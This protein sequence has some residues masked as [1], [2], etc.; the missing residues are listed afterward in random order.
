MYLDKVVVPQYAITLLIKNPEQT[1]NCE[2]FYHDIGDYLSREDKLKI[3][4]EFGDIAGIEAVKGWQSISPNDSYDW[5]NQR[6]PAFDAFMSLGDKKDKTAKTIFDVY[7][8]GVHTAR[9]A[10]CY[11]FLSRCGCCQYGQND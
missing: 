8:D 2:L 6:D 5:I 7:S 9:D 11:N 1:G 4:Q 10:W 3:I